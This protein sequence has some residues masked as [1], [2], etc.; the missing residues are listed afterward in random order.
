MKYWCL[1]YIQ[2]TC[3]FY[4]VISEVTIIKPGVTL[5]FSISN[6]RECQDTDQHHLFYLHES[7]GDC[8]LRCG[9]REQCDGLLY[10]GPMSLCQLF[11][12]G[13]E[14]VPST[15]ST[16]HCVH[17]KRKDIEIIQVSQPVR[18]NVRVDVHLC[19]SIYFS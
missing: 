18:E 4:S 2:V 19:I 3:L 6:D 15:G 17:I 9:L 12:E 8:I 16:G 7:L 13:G 11:T 14:I 5:R 10:N 1:L